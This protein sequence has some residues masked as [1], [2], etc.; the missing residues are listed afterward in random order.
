MSFF[1][2]HSSVKKGCS[3][4]QGAHDSMTVVQ[5]YKKVAFSFIFK[6]VPSQGFL[7]FWFFSQTWEG[8]ETI[9]VFKKSVIVQLMGIRVE[10]IEA[11]EWF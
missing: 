8:M 5:D 3:Y 1:N 9:S 7:F 2:Q 6:L 11:S 10:V 4:Q